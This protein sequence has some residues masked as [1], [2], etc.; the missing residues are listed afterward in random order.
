MSYAIDLF[1]DGKRVAGEGEAEFICRNPATGEEI[2]RFREASPD[3][4]ETAVAS[5]TRAQKDWAATP[6]EQR[7]RIL[8]KAADLLRERNDKLA[9]IEME[10]TGKPIGE[11]IG[12]RTYR[13][14][15]AILRS[16]R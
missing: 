6:A 11:A 8:R 5:A 4:I 13:H 14:L 7:G 15:V 9:H 1:I 2:G 12:K 16:A 10:D 3:Q